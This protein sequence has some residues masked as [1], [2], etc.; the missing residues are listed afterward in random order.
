MTLC[1]SRPQR[2]TRVPWHEI[3]VDLIGTWSISI[4]EVEYK[5]H[6]LTIIGNV[7]N[8][9]EI[10]QLPNKLSVHMALQFEN[11]WLS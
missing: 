1:A 2:F 10:I 7:A 6:A 3:V 4:Q 8:Y 9:L 5:F 11:T